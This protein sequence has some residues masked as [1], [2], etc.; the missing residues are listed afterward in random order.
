MSYASYI[1]GFL[2]RNGFGVDLFRK[3]L[4]V[5]QDPAIPVY[6]RYRLYKS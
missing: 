3:N 6:R 2:R 1:S 5:K 4:V